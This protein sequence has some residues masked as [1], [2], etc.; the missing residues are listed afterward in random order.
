VRIAGD[1]AWVQAGTSKHSRWKQIQ[2]RFQA[3]LMP[4][5]HSPK[6]KLSPA[7]QFFCLGSCFARNIEEHLIYR[8]ISVLSKAIVCPREEWSARP[9]GL[10]NKFTTASM[11]NELDWISSSPSVEN[12]LIEG[13]RGW[14]D[15]QLAP[16]APPVSLER[17]IARRRYLQTEYFPRIRRANV[18]ILTLGLIEA[19]FDTK[20]GIYLNGAPS[21]W[22]TRKHQGRFHFE[23]LSI[24]A[25]VHALQQIHAR[26]NELAPGAKIIV[27]VSPVPLDL[28]FTNLDVTVANVYSKSVLRAAAEVFASSHDDV[29]YFPSYEMVVLSRREAAFSDRDFR[30]VKDDMVNE[31][32]ECFVLDYVGPLPRR[33]PDFIETQYL[34]ENPDVEAAVRQGTLISAYHHWL[35]VSG[36]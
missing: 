13:E 22:Q 16:P 23:Q 11:L 24:D 32:V 36:G 20:A 14:H 3:D 31:I 10:V 35:G 1:Q 19:W 33:F 27:T 8:D 34:A 7:D 15:L 9:N 5:K 25:N 29:D 12:L 2:P 4:V 26:L 17:A 6:F 28:T 21:S 18:V 30:H